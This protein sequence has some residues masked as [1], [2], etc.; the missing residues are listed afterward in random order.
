MGDPTGAHSRAGLGMVLGG[1]LGLG[2]GLVGVALAGAAIGAIVLSGGA[3]LPIVVGAGFGLAAAGV[4]FFAAIAGGVSAGGKAGQTFKG[5]SCGKITTGSGAKGDG[6][7]VFI[8]HRRAARAQI[9]ELDHGSNALIESGSSTVFINGKP[10]AREGEKGGCGGLMLERCAQRTFIGGESTSAGGAYGSSIIAAADE[11]G[12]LLGKVALG[13]GVAA[14]VGPFLLGGSV[15]ALAG[16]GAVL[17]AGLL[18][19]EKATELGAQA[20]KWLDSQGERTEGRWENIL[21]F[22]GGSSVSFFNPMKAGAVVGRKAPVSALFVPS[23]AEVA[24]GAKYLTTGV[25]TESGPKRSFIRDL[26]GRRATGEP[27]AAEARDTGPTLPAQRDAE[28]GAGEPRPQAP[29]EDAALSLRGSV[30]RA[31]ERAAEARPRA[32]EGTG[33]GEGA[34]ATGSAKPR[35]ERYE[36]LD[37]KV[38][39]DEPM[40]FAERQEWTRLRLAD[41]RLAREQRTTPGDATI[42]DPGCS[43]CA[44]SRRSTNSPEAAR[45][46]SP[47]LQEKIDGLA[48]RGDHTALPRGTNKNGLLAYLAKKPVEYG[49]FRSK[50]TGQLYVVRGDES[51]VAPVGSADRLIFHNHPSG[52]KHLSGVGKDPMSGDVGYIQDR[53]PN[54]KSSIIGTPDGH[55]HRNAVPRVE[56][57]YPRR[58]PDG[59]VDWNYKADIPGRTIGGTGHE[60]SQPFTPGQLRDGIAALPN[61]GSPSQLR[62]GIRDLQPPRRVALDPAGQRPRGDQA[63]DFSARRQPIEWR[64]VGPRERAESAGATGEPPLDRLHADDTTTSSQSYAY[65]QNQPTRDIVESLKPGRPDSLKVDDAGKVWD[66]NTRVKVLEERG[67]DV[68]SLPRERHART[69]LDG[70]RVG[71][72]PARRAAEDLFAPRPADGAPETG[73]GQRSACTTCAAPP[74]AAAATVAA[75]AKG[76]RTTPPRSLPSANELYDFARQGRPIDPSVATTREGRAQLRRLWLQRA[77]LQHAEE[78]A[79]RRARADGWTP[80]AHPRRAIDLSVA[81]PARTLGPDARDGA[82]AY[83]LPDGWTELWVH[84]TPTGFAGEVPGVPGAYTPRTVTEVADAVRMQGGSGPVLLV[85]CEAGKLTTA[86]PNAA[87]QLANELGRPVV[88]MSHVVAGMPGGGYAPAGIQTTVPTGLAAIPQVDGIPYTS[89]AVQGR[90]R[91]FVPNPVDLVLPLGGP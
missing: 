52:A 59:S 23:K 70:N 89:G 77:S 32:G 58:N 41:M 62:D 55:T 12:A 69:D 27:R 74:P 68:D 88:A 5:G 19:G 16:G 57:Q 50:E 75:A 54:Q 31:R 38:K 63:F 24:F 51:I 21:G 18:L 33:E 7:P 2:I 6:N 25:A 15:L 71:V 53:N 84:G 22:V 43:T 60:A 78:Q 49:V 10:A 44:K 64:E 87:Q 66:G 81:G 45:T 11:V 28:P 34:G 39:R 80:E 3:A 85:A 13:L 65:W 48:K 9:D 30:A 4:G 72:S 46:L 56:E 47:A 76:F 86:G 17:G 26:R 67:Y 73:G 36:T 1:L 42:S 90:W 61:G 82:G 37:G 79:E 83:R 14:V 8:E 40:T 20:G 91:T 29:L 35:S